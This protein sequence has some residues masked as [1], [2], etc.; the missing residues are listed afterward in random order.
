[1]NYVTE[2][3]FIGYNL[4]FMVKLKYYVAWLSESV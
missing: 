2:N 1:M 4:G 3:V